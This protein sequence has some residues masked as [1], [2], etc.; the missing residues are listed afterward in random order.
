[1]HRRAGGAEVVARGGQQQNRADSAG[2]EIECCSAAG[3]PGE[4]RKG[5]GIEKGYAPGS[6]TAKLSR[7]C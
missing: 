6:R 1:M 4:R 2:K 5:S 3:A 7:F